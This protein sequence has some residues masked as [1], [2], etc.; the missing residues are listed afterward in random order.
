MPKAA[1]KVMKTALRSLKVLIIDEISVVSSLNLAYIHMRL[2]ELLTGLEEE[3]CYLLVTCSQ[4]MAALCLKL[5]LKN[6]YD[7]N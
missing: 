7:S 1:H 6:H 3:M 2:E 4:S 5:Y